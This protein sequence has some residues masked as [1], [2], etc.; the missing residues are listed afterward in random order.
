MRRVNEIILAIA[1][2]GL[3][4]VAMLIGIP[5]HSAD[6]GTVVGVGSPFPALPS[7]TAATLPPLPPLLFPPGSSTPVPIQP[8]TSVSGGLPPVSGVGGLIQSISP[9]SRTDTTSSAGP[10]AVPGVPAPSPATAPPTTSPP[11]TSPP[12]T[13]APATTSPPT[14]APPT[15]APPT[16]DPPTTAPPTTAPPTTAP[17]TTEPPTTA[18]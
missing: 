1:A 14:T 16:T 17:P 11:G 10:V 18:S 5:T 4:A 7:T 9:I 12:P 8:P 6:P 3:V 15:T 2:A 13:T